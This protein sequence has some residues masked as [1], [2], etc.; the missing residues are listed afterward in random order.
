MPLGDRTGPL[1]YGP[2]TGRASGYCAG[3]PGPGYINLSSGWG[4]GFGRGRR[5]R[6]NW[7]LGAGR[8][9]WPQTVYGYPYHR[10]YLYKTEIS[11][12]DEIE[13]LKRQADQMQKMLSEVNRRMQELESDK[14]E[15]A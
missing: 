9:W 10:D 8:G 7:F 14:K 12:E 1:G 3:Y 6:G 11:K 4:F 2:M 15:K 5:G 13:L